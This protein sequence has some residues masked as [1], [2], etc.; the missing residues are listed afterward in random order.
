MSLLEF[1]IENKLPFIPVTYKIIDDEHNEGYVKKVMNASP[2]N[3]KTWTMSKCQEYYNENKSDFVLID[4][5]NKFCIVD[6]D[7]EES[8]TD[9]CKFFDKIDAETKEIYL[10]NWATNGTSYYLEQIHK[11]K[12]K[13]S[14]FKYHFWFKI[15]DIQPKHKVDTKRKLDVITKHIAENINCCINTD[16]PEFSFNKSIY[17]KV[18]GVKYEENVESEL[19][20]TYNDLSYEEKT[21]YDTLDK[22]K[23]KELLGKPRVEVYLNTLQER[24]KKIIVQYQ[25]TKPKNNNETFEFRALS[26]FYNNTWVH[27]K[28]IITDN[29]INCYDMYKELFEIIS[30]NHIEEYQDWIIIGLAINSLNLQFFEKCLL[31]TE[32]SKF[33][34]KYKNQSEST[35]RKLLLGFNNNNKTNVVTIGTVRYWAKKENPPAYK[36]WMNKWSMGSD[37]E[38]LE[39]IECSPSPY[40][41]IKNINERYLPEV[42][43]NNGFTIINSHLGTGKTT[44][45]SKFI[46]KNLN[47]NIIVITPREIYAQNICAELNKNGFD[48][49][50]YQDYKNKNT[51]KVVCQAESLHKYQ[52]YKYDI[53]IMDECESILKQLSSLETHRHNYSQNIE[54]FETLMNESSK[55][56]MADAF[57]TNRSKYFVDY[58]KKPVI[59]INNQFNPY[60]RECVEY[61]NY[62]SFVSQIFKSIQKGKKI[63]ILW[64]SKKRGQRFVE[65]EL[66]KHHMK[67]K[68]YYFYHGDCDKKYNETIKNVNEN[69]SNIDLLMYT[70]KITVGVNFDKLYYDELY[71]YATPDSAV[72]R[73][74]F[75]GSL[76]VRHLKD[77]LLHYYIESEH[78]YC[79]GQTFITDLEKI[80][81]QLNNNKYK[82]ESFVKT[83]NIDYIVFKQMP[84]WLRTVHTR[85]LYEE[86]VNKSHYEKV[87]NKYLS[88]CGYKKKNITKFDIIKYKAG[89]LK[90]HSNYEDIKDLTKDEYIRLK[91]KKSEFYEL[92]NE[93][94][95]RMHKFEFHKLFDM[96]KI[97]DNG[98]PINNLYNSY[99]VKNKTKS[100]SNFLNELKMDDV[101]LFLC[102]TKY[103]EFG[104]LVKNDYIK[105]NEIKSISKILGLKHSLDNAEIKNENLT[106]CFKYLES[107]F[108]RLHD[109]FNLRDQSSHGKQGPITNRNLTELL[110][111][112]L[113]SWTSGRLS[114]VSKKQMTCPKLKKRVWVINY[115]IVNQIINEPYDDYLIIKKH[116]ENKDV[117]N[118]DDEVIVYNH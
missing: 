13:D 74:L 80:E 81:H 14:H 6:C 58:F 38:I 104:E 3:W 73:D 59:Y 2:I 67:D 11:Q 7:S 100:F 72:C 92:T 71:I 12:I 75:Q 34:S 85:N 60:N 43:I 94:R 44:F 35:C 112:L 5:Q 96:N 106:E 25:K 22:C 37:N 86:N 36:D 64:G 50:L 116:I 54:I 56:I 87:F 42:D 65:S 21:L 41:N 8:T 103:Q 19:T 111:K 29:I 4:L 101:K 97:K 62:N 51:D 79:K 49:A 27:K 1:C 20:F 115:K 30:I 102:D 57:I 28:N 10:R 17:K 110:N 16:A 46:Q 47:K 48:F 32:V 24:I 66:F 105:L 117:L 23:K 18:Y 107:N 70:T 114:V 99:F 33:S 98:F 84:E 77:N 83:K 63:C 53:V 90:A 118:F 55:I 69:W 78:T 88:L 82:S 93:E 68:K 52:D 113:D 89:E 91:Q 108:D 40:W 31:Y 95:E 39:T 61:T 26:L 109:I 45:I 15:V 76:R 9:F